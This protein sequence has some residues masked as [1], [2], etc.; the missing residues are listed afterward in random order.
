MN[1]LLDATKCLL[2]LYFDVRVRVP[3]WYLAFG[4]AKCLFKSFVLISDGIPRTHQTQGMKMNDWTQRIVIF[5]T[6][7]VLLFSFFLFNI[8][9]GLGFERSGLIKKDHRKTQSRRPLEITFSMVMMMM[10]TKM[11][12][13]VKRKWFLFN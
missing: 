7:C 13:D 2:V 3:F 6:I 12:I 9:L 1:F 4:R 11:M 8:L 5:H 10:M